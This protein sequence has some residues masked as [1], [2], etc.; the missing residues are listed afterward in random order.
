MRGYAFMIILAF[1]AV[2]DD[3]Y[4]SEVRRD[5][6]IVPKRRKIDRHLFRV[7]PCRLRR[8]KS[9]KSISRPSDLYGG[10]KDKS[11]SKT[12]V[13]DIRISAYIFSISRAESSAN[14]LSLRYVSI[15]IYLIFVAL[16]TR[17]ENSFCANFGVLGLFVVE[18]G[19]SEVF[20]SVG[21]KFDEDT[22]GFTSAGTV[23]SVTGRPVVY[24]LHPGGGSDVLL[25]LNGSGLAF[26][27]EVESTGGVVESDG[28]IPLSTRSVLC[29]DSTFIMDSKRLFI[30][31]FILSITEL[32]S[33]ILLPILDGIGS[34]SSLDAKA[35]K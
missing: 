8:N 9:S 12:K 19:A 6:K 23:L 15:L 30:V 35:S 33:S 10:R 18:D 26:F 4:L 25:A 16:E 17:R 28:N 27:I 22:S 34:S 13:S 24:G 21:G 3:I 2:N 32:R 14:F 7:K 5:F 20:V 31:V 29:T 11:I 1:G